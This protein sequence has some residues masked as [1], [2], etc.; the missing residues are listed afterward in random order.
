MRANETEMRERVEKAKQYL[1]E[2]GS[3]RGLILNGITDDNKL[4]IFLK[5]HANEFSD[6]K[7]VKR[8]ER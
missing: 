6:I 1:I 7:F 2:N 5:N 8:G 3:T 4:Y